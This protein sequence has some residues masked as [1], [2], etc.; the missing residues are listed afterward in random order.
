MESMKGF[1]AVEKLISQVGDLT[2]EKMANDSKLTYKAALE[3]VLEENPDLAEKIRA[4]RKTMIKEQIDTMDEEK[5]LNPG[6]NFSENKRRTRDDFIFFCDELAKE[7][8]IRPEARSVV[9]DFMEIFSRAPVFEFNEGTGKRKDHPLNRF[10]SFLGGLPKRELSPIESANLYHERIHHKTLTL[11]GFLGA[12]PPAVAGLPA[13]EFTEEGAKIYEVFDFAIREEGY[14]HMSEEDSVIAGIASASP[15]Q[16]IE[17]SEQGLFDWRQILKN[18][19]PG[20]YKSEEERVAAM[21][22]SASP[23]HRAGT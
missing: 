8:K 14:S 5:I 20:A 19:G 3:Q 9:V 17:F 6:G 21:I 22:A 2:S 4:Y 15:K 7:G 23:K 10:R 11:I 18:N 1:D 13:L 16:T 12:T